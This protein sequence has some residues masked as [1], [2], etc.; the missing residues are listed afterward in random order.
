MVRLKT[1]FGWVLYYLIARNLPVSYSKFSFGS[2]KIRAFCASLI[3]RKTGKN[4]NIEKGAIFSSKLIIGDNSGLGINCKA[5]GPIT[6]G[7]N[8][9]IGPD[10]VMLTRNH[11]F[12]DTRIPMNKQ[13]YSKVK[14][15]SIGNDVWIGER[16]IILP[17]VQ[18]GQ[19][20]VVGAGAVVSKNIPDFA[21]AVGNPI[22]IKKMRNN[23]IKEK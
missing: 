16:V 18:I 4:I 21:V 2:K 8:V 6:I 5:A 22:Q 14:P 12:E 10:V 23:F 19:G 9:M 15:I 20:V 17:G 7:N 11:K 3:A 1:Y 13:G